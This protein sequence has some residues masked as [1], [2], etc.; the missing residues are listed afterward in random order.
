MQNRLSTVP[1]LPEQRWSKY[2]HDLEKGMGMGENEHEGDVVDAFD[3]HDED[4]D[5][6][7]T[8][9]PPLSRPAAAGWAEPGAPRRIAPFSRVARAAEEA[10][11]PQL[12]LLPRL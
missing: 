6:E 2:G 10:Y 11:G 8:S 3:E 5:E 4:E 12:S 9:L 1:T 7:V